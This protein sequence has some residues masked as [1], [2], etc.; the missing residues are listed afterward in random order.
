MKP[1]KTRSQPI[2]KNVINWYD[3]ITLEILKKKPITSIKI[4]PHLDISNKKTFISK[5]L[6]KI[7]CNLNLSKVHNYHL[8]KVSQKEFTL[9]F[10]I[11]F[12]NPFLVTIDN[13]ELNSI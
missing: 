1:F 12:S 9:N 10:M 11:S 8:V 7:K 3:E 5:G 6:L 4:K 2:L 13:L